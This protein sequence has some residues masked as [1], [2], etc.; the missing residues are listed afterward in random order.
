MERSPPLGK[1][2]ASGSPTIRFLPLNTMMGLPSSS[3]KKESC[4]SAVEPVRGWNQWVK[5]V[6]PRSRAQRFMAWA[7]SLA[8]LASRGAPSSM[9][10]KSFST[11][12]G[13][14]CIW[15]EELYL[16]PEHCD[17]GFGS[18][19]LRFVKEKYPEAIMRLEVEAENRRAMH[20]YRKNG[21][22]EM[23]YIEM[24]V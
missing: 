3:S 8:M 10:A 21:F 7:T 2:E 11:E 13:C 16:E 9:V 20:V 18:A 6:A 15:I 5:W 23:P 12:Y 4:F 24:K 19:F 17:Q 14:P 1:L 22:E